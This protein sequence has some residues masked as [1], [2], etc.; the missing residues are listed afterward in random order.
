M[1][2]E[3]KNKSLQS[4]FLHL[5][6]IA[7]NAREVA[8]YKSVNNVYNSTIMSYLSSVLSSTEIYFFG[9]F[10]EKNTQ[11]AAGD[12]KTLCAEREEEKLE[13]Q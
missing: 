1:Q 4:K 2:R 3:K 6:I 12:Q 7:E 11:Q 8:C 5:K 13:L 9:I 10:H